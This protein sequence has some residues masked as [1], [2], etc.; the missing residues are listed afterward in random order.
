LLLGFPEKVNFFRL[1]YPFIQDNLEVLL[2]RANTAILKAGSVPVL[3]MQQEGMVGR[4]L[5]CIR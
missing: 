5:V 2:D 3:E 1:L 4:V